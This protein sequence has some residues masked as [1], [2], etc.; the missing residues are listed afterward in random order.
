VVRRNSH[1]DKA[2]QIR[3]VVPIRHKVHPGPGGPW[4][5]VRVAYSAEHAL[6]KWDE[7]NNEGWE[8]TSEPQRI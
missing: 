1:A 7:G 8:R 6:L 2:W 4:F 5:F 3:I